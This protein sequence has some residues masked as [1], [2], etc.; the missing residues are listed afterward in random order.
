MRRIKLTLLLAV[1]ASQQ[2]LAQ[3]TETL[4]EMV[5]QPVAEKKKSLNTLTADFTTGWITTEVTT[6]EDSYK[7]R[8][9]MGFEFSFRKLYESGCGI[10]L[11]YAHS[12]T[13]YPSRYYNG[14]YWLKANY[15]GVSVLYGGFVGR[16][17]IAT[18]GIGAGCGYTYGSDKGE[19]GFGLKETLN[20]EYQLSSLIGIG[21]GLDYFLCIS[22]KQQDNGYNNR[23]YDVNGFK[24]LALH[25]GL[26]VYF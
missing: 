5:D 2:A 17:C 21:A 22:N 9:G 25:A 6:P 26:R 12:E 13:G 14:K 23:K 4:P 10:S 7:W 20:V 11:E 15:Y 19:V 8:N 1:L 16:Q 24:R 18:I 3:M